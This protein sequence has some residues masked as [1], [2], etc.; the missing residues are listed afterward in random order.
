MLH[1]LQSA[2]PPN[3]T[4]RS[5][6]RLFGIISLKNLKLSP[7]TALLAIPDFDD[8]PLLGLPQHVD[9][10]CMVY[11]WNYMA[12]LKTSQSATMS[13]L[14]DLPLYYSPAAKWGSFAI[15]LKAIE[16]SI[17]L[18]SEDNSPPLLRSIS[19][20]V[21]DLPR[22]YYEFLSERDE[23][24]WRAEITTLIVHGRRIADLALTR[25][26]VVSISGRSNLRLVSCARPLWGMRPARGWWLGH[27]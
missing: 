13:F 25:L 26:S 11:L 10:A 15:L 1:H 19:N 27:A 9:N 6:K 4:F 16:D 24:K 7:I 17:A 22:L 18:P 2:V 5:D 20:R 8:L 23:N 3:I 14:I 12:S 21:L